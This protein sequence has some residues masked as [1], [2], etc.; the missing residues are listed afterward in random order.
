MRV[1][2][3]RRVARM[4]AALAAVML[5]AEAALASSAAALTAQTITFN[6]PAFGMVG[7]TLTIGATA[8]SGLP[9]TLIAF[10]DTQCTVSGTTLTLVAQGTCYVDASQ[11][12]DATYAAA[13]TVRR[14][15][16]AKLAQTIDFS[17]AATGFVSATIGMDA[18]STSGLAVTYSTSTPVICTVNGSDLQLIAAGTCTVTASQPGSDDWTAAT[19]VT[20]VIS[21]S[22]PPWMTAD[23]AF[24]GR[25]AFNGTVRAMAID[26]ESGVTFVGGTF[27]QVG[28]RTGAVAHVSAP[29]SG[30]DSLLASS[31]DVVSH[32]VLVFPDGAS[33]YFAVGPIGSING[34]GVHR[35]GITRIASTGVVDSTWHSTDPC[36]SGLEPRWDIGTS[37][38]ATMELAQGTTGYTTTGLAFIDK[39]TG[40]MTFAG[41]GGGTC[42][43]GSRVWSSIPTFAPLAACAGM[44][45]C[46]A[47]N[48][49]LTHQPANHLLVTD[50]IV[51]TSESASGPSTT[52]RYLIA[53][54]TVAGARLW[55]RELEAAQRPADVPPTADW[56]GNV[57]TMV[58]IGDT[59]LLVGRFPLDGPIATQSSM[60]LISAT[61]GSVLQRWNAA[62]EQ[63]LADP[64]TTIAPASTCVP[65]LLGWSS[66][67]ASDWSLVPVTAGLAIGY[68]SPTDTPRGHEVA[69][70][71]YSTTGSGQNAR[72]AAVLRGTLV[73]RQDSQH[74][75]IL[76]SALH[77]G[78]YVV[79]GFGAFDLQTNE[80]VSG[81]NPSPSGA[82][83][84]VASVGEMLVFGGNIQFLHGSP[85]NHVAALDTNL[86]PV[87]GWEAR[88]PEGS[89]DG[90]GTQDVA[91]MAL[92]GGHLIVTGDIKTDAGMAA[93]V[94]LDPATGAVNWANEDLDVDGT[95]LAID[96]STGAFYLGAWSM[97][98]SKTLR[99]FTPKANGFVVD[100][101][102]VHTLSPLPD[103]PY[104][105]KAFI[106]ALALQGSHLYIG[107]VFAGVD[108]HPRQGLARLTNGVVDAW[109]PSPITE[110]GR[111]P[112]DII[113]VVP[114]AFVEVGPYVVV[115]GRF[116]RTPSLPGGL[117]GGTILLPSV[118]AYDGTTGA[119]ARPVG[120]NEPWYPDE[121][122]GT[123]DMRVIDGTLFV[124]FG[125]S[126]VGAFD[127]AT[128][129]YL[130]SRS[131]RTQ[132]GWGE[133]AIVAIG[134]RTGV[135]QGGASMSAAVTSAPETLV[136][137]GDL[138]H[139]SNVSAGNVVA[140]PPSDTLT[141]NKT[142]SGR[143][144]V[145][146]QPLGLSCGST[147]SQKF[148]LN[149]Q[150]VLTATPVS[151]GTF[152]GWSGGGCSGT[153]T[154][155][156][157]LTRATS[158]TATF[159]D[160]AKPTAT[161]P[162]AALR[163]STSLSGSSVRIRVSWTASD[164]GGS[165]IKRYE[166]SKS[167]NGGTSWTVVSTTLTGTT[168]DAI[169]ASSGSI[170]YRVRAVDKAGN[171]GSWMY[172]PNLTARLTQQSSTSVKY[173]KTWTAYTLSSC[174]G[175]SARYS[176][177]AGATA[178][179]TFTGRAIGFVTT[180]SWTRGQARIY[181]NGVLQA[182]IDLR[183]SS[184]S[185]R[186]V[187]WQMTWSTSA[188]RT[189]KVEVVG[190]SGRPRAD[191]D[192]FAVLR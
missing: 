101:T 3:R 21:V 62:G 184:T 20:R 138:A 89:N 178:S 79:G 84:S 102:F 71:A 120:T 26:E 189:I 42:T 94:A 111:Q 86:A 54:D 93:V 113:E 153:S 17:I 99:R 59:I 179:Y 162:T 183:A 161:A 149:R 144:T 114:Q 150:V 123:F 90:T 45:T 166:L 96:P 73:A 98:P 118:L 188:T 109:A 53:Y 136:L 103:Y 135:P 10:D 22:L 97:T 69:V 186:V 12:G 170:R 27:T 70:C 171:V 126:G 165:G 68:A 187:A 107:G 143:G 83:A 142:G 40:I 19:P 172:G 65:A 180:K 141:I 14:S 72:L 47:A 60:V 176:T 58:A 167:T 33:G 81:W 163:N 152:S 31:P 91:D 134:V 174:S 78:R 159:S 57:K 106:T 50:T 175:G 133:N 137:G 49:G 39:A 24:L 185:Y 130:P 6:L 2:P 127:T 139:W 13:P 64:A 181:I 77:L 35:R 148:P 76:P 155:T 146:S 36:S 85:A 55:S 190:T 16:Q 30:S 122:L 154:C 48:V 117:W 80:Q 15:I 182:T 1:G 168:H 128:L 7:D 92:V 11:P 46:V 157:T 145:S 29:D 121:Y 151:G 158:V 82:P 160:F 140:I 43:T 56:G 169:V 74:S 119:R 124:A 9:V 132:T 129:D 164:T 32:Q 28:I 25:Y 38:V 116:G 125:Y 61:A 8:S 44:F 156:I 23:G 67:D 105:N 110:L 147:C 51:V 131:T 100:A 177:T 63:S 112:G 75:W 88:L 37:L 104:D 115:D 108:A 5:A 95:A 34:D 41:G 173:G 4:V 52:R 87:S 191:L 66:A 18:T 192:A